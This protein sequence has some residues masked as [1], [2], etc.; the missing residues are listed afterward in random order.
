[1]LDVL[2]S[3]DGTDE[4]IIV[5]DLRIPRTVLGLIVGMALGVAG[6]LM[7]GHTRNPFA[8]PGLLGVTAGPRSRWYSVSRCSA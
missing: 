1:M 8:D 5:H 2:F 7:Q 4:S 3:P 6:A